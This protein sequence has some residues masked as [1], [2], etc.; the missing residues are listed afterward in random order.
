MTIIGSK[1]DYREADYRFAR[2]QSTRTP[3]EHSDRIHS[4]LDA[5][6]TWGIIIASG[7]AGLRI[8]VFIY[9]AAINQGWIR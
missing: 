6:I 7:C 5:I 4:R 8:A 3:W 9:E 2:V 1:S